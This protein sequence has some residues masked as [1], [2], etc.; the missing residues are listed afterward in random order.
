MRD[1]EVK[2]NDLAY[3]IKD[4][5]A[6]IHDEVFARKKADWLKFKNEE[7]Y[8]PPAMRLYSAILIPMFFIVAMILEKV[9]GLGLAFSVLLPGI[10]IT[11][12]LIIADEYSLAETLRERIENL[13]FN[14]R[15]S[16]K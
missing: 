13:N 9:S 14:K 11:V 1:N 5:L 10:G 6:P 7:S 4:I 8:K 15:S 2:L 3:Q 16:A 12:A